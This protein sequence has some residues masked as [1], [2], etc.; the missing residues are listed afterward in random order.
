MKISLCANKKVRAVLGLV[1][2]LLFL[3][4]AVYYIRSHDLKVDLRLLFQVKASQTVSLELVVND[5]S[6]KA[7]P[8]QAP[9]YRYVE[10]K[11]PREA[12]RNIELKLGARPVTIAVRQVKLKSL[13]TSYLW[14]N[15]AIPKLFGGKRGAGKVD[16]D[17]G[18]ITIESTGEG[19]R[20]PLARTFPNII[21]KVAG[22]KFIYYLLAVVCS[23]FLFMLIFLLDP[24][25]LKIF[26]PS[27]H[28]SGTALIF[29]LSIFF[30]LLN[31]VFRVVTPFDIQEKR[32][33]RPRPSFRLDAPADFPEQYREYYNDHFIMRN[34]FIRINNLI[35]F[36]LFNKSPVP[37][38]VIGKNG[39][40]FM[41]RETDS[42]D[43]I[44][45]FRN[46][47]PFTRKE[48][49]HWNRILEERRQWLS[50]QG[51]QYLFVVV[52]NKSTVYPEFMP[53]RIRR[54]NERSRLD[55]LLE[56]TRNH[57]QV[58]I[59]DLRDALIEA[60]HR[61]PVFQKTDS[62]W[63]DFGAYV[64][65]REI[66]K[67]LNGFQKNEKPMP[68]SRFDIRSRNWVGG[69]LAAALSLQKEVIRENTLKMVP[70]SPLSA[71]TVSRESL[72]RY[73]TKSVSASSAGKLPPAMMVH[74]SFI[75][76][77]RPFLAE[78]FSRMVFIWDWGLNIYPDHIRSEKPWIVIE[79]MAERY[80]LDKILSNPEIVAR[81]HGRTAD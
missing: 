81:S 6:L 47:R 7:N 64:A 22:K 23:I 45:Y 75:H 60:K 72:S 12:V 78:H 11:L 46:T 1:S 8:V 68:L 42:R 71:R 5:H 65:Y 62:H 14:E 31:S 44:E 40:L 52:P 74:D 41:S 27:R 20:L 73:I 26:L 59:L 28:F 77:L 4:L 2:A 3:I 15:E 76:E 43:E 54:I 17:R 55:Q 13:F 32:A 58:R 35:S 70:V 61:F 37:M 50:R 29:L 80:L 57:S 66:I 69:D 53:D 67:V 18:I 39:W 33:L 25:N 36:K 38:V 49:A 34:R 9:G 63:N 51:I 21:N 48:L 24:G 79:E 56:H 19:S 30:P 16:V 10:F